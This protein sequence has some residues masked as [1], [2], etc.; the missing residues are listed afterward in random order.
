MA[1]FQIVS[2]L[3]LENPKAY[4]LFEIAP[5]APYLALLGDIGNVR[6]DG[7]LLF[8]EDQLRKFEIVFLVMGNHEPFHS[9]WLDVREKLKRFSDDITRKGAQMQNTKSGSH[10]LGKFVLLDQTRYDLAP[11]LTVLGCTFHSKVSDLQEERVTEIARSN[12]H[13]R[14][15]IF[16][17]HSPTVAPLA[18]D[19]A[20]A[21][22]PISSA[23]AT[24]LAGEACWEKP[25]VRLW[26]F[27]H[28]HYNCDFTDSRT[29]KRI[30]ANQR[31]YYFSQA[32]VFE[33]EKVI[34]I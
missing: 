25:Q 22:S 11:D 12:P 16:T 3:H 18:V 17:H 7:F 2:D 32:K 27:G 8:I 13:H 10:N 31:G 29:G 15:V 30:V 21:K 34:S 1:R 14:I 24:D 4:D 6:D 26:G 28:T 33:P 20:H 19:P 9:S 5:K 23:F